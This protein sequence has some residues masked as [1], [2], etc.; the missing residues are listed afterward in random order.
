MEERRATEHEIVAG[1]IGCLPT[2]VVRDLH[3][4]IIV[5]LYKFIEDAENELSDL[6][7]DKIRDIHTALA[8]YESELERAYKRKTDVYQKYLSQQAWHL[9]PDLDIVP[10]YLKD[11]DIAKTDEDIKKLDVEIERMEKKIRAQ[12]KFNRIYQKTLLYYELKNLK[13]DI[14]ICITKISEHMAE[15]LGTGQNLSD[16][17]EIMKDVMQQIQQLAHQS[18]WTRS[19]LLGEKEEMELDNDENVTSFTARYPSQRIAAF[20]NEYVSTFPKQQVLDEQPQR[21]KDPQEKGESY[22]NEE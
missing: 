6:H 18:P 3:T 12:R 4:A 11:I 20:I 9:P 7:P 14:E 1:A 10:E 8:R 15:A 2:K 19:I 17:L 16:D 13:T 5:R 22:G 21:A